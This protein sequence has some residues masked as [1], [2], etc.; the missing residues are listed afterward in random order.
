MTR[1]TIIYE[2]IDQG[3]G[4]IVEN[5]AT[6][7]N[8][9]EEYPIVENFNFNDPSYVLG[10]ATDVRREDNGEI[11]CEVPEEVIIRMPKNPYHKDPDNEETALVS[12]AAYTNGVVAKPP[13]GKNNDEKETG[14][15]RITTCVLRAVGRIPHTA[16]NPGASIK[17]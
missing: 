5:G 13:L 2:G 1:V 14:P 6:E 12:F 17:S 11:T 3:F 16:A 8:E 9:G 15:R 10:K 7:W 4:Y